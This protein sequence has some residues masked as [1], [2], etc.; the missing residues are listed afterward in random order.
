M[1]KKKKH[2]GVVPQTLAVYHQKGKKVKTQA[3]MLLSRYN[4]ENPKDENEIKAQPCPKPAVKAEPCQLPAEEGLAMKVEPNSPPLLTNREMTGSA[5]DNVEGR[6]QEGE[7]GRGRVR[8]ASRQRARQLTPRE[9]RRSTV[10]E[11]R[12]PST[13]SSRNPQSATS[14]L[15]VLQWCSNLRVREGEQPDASAVIR[16][17][18]ACQMP[19]SY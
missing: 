3:A 5:R 10:W 6:A 16:R 15:R 8:D 11:P 1:S 13:P 17:A 9:R 18:L 14:A 2:V 4:L 19:C 12:H 7:R